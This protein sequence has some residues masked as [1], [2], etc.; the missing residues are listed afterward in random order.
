M[1]LNDSNA[2]KIGQTK[3]YPEGANHP[4]THTEY[5]CACGKGKIIFERVVG[6][7]DYYAFFK[8]PECEKKYR[9]KYGCGHVWELEEK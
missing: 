5:K 2:I 9:F 8:C 6:F 1:S 4:T 7:D 3:E